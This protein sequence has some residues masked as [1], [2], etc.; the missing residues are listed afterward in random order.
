MA[1]IIL[2]PIPVYCKLFAFGKTAAK[3]DTEIL[4]T[5]IYLALTGLFA[6]MVFYGTYSHVFIQT[7]T[8]HYTNNFNKYIIQT[9][10]IF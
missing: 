7:Y 4:Y 5:L 2:L 3:K 10:K 1:L 8:G 6:L 9:D